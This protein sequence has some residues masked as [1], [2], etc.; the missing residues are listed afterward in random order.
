MSHQRLLQSLTF[1]SSWVNARIGSFCQ[2]M[3]GKASLVGLTT[4]PLT[5]LPII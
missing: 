4:L 3:E 5:T 2:L 1:D